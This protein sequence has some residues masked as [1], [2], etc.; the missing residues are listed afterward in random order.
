MLHT[1]VALIVQNNS[2]L[3]NAASTTQKKTIR[4]CNLNRN[5]L[6]VLY[7]QLTKVCDCL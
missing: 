6:V 3:S 4:R 5:N 7:K 2:T 1:T